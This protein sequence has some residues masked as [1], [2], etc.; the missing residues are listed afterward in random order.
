MFCRLYQSSALESKPGLIFRKKADNNSILPEETTLPPENIP[1]R[2]E[3]AI[4]LIII[5][6]HARVKTIF[7][8]KVLFF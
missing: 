1:N 3:I 5:G 8:N 6:I 2:N 4:F 7:V